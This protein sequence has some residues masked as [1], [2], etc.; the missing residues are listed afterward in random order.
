MLTAGG[1]VKLRKNRALKCEALFDLLMAP[2]M[3]EMA[4][5]NM[6]CVSVLYID[7]FKAVNIFKIGIL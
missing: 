1:K 6:Y 4:N 3:V 2:S 5:L 7:E